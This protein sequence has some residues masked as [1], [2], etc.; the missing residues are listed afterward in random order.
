MKDEDEL[1]LATR[2]FLISHSVCTTENL[3]LSL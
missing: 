1:L 2:K 3:I